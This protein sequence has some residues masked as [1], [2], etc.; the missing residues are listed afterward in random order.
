MFGGSGRG[1]VHSL[2]LNLT[3][4]FLAETSLA[5]GETGVAASRLSRGST[6]SLATVQ[7]LIS[8]VVNGQVSVWSWIMLLRLWLAVSILLGL[9][10]GVVADED[11]DARDM[12]GKHMSR[13]CP[14]GTL[15]RSTA[16]QND[17]FLACPTEA[18]SDYVSAVQVFGN[19]EAIVPPEIVSEQR[20]K[21]ILLRKRSGVDTFD[22][23]VHLCRPGGSEL[24][25]VVQNSSTGVAIPSSL[26]AD[27]K[28][29]MRFWMS[30]ACLDPEVEIKRNK[31]IR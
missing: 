16:C 31:T 2:G 21:L 27:E 10:T 28:T 4:R 5:K 12:C 18:L 6:G 9:S 26:V 14:P 22:Q 11:E 1:C 17:P 13:H 24:V 23:A 30:T 3:F 25:T 29:K 15:A 7:L 19:L 20:S 8:I